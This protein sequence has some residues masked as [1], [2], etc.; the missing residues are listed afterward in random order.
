MDQLQDIWYSIRDN[1]LEIWDGLQEQIPFLS[2]IP[3]YKVYIISGAAV[4]MS[5]L[6]VVKTL[7][8]N[9][10]AA[11]LEASAANY[12][13]GQQQ[14]SSVLGD[15][16]TIG[17]SDDAKEI[18]GI[19]NLTLQYKSLTSLPSNSG[20]KTMQKNLGIGDSQTA[21]ENED[22]NSAMSSTIKEF[23][24]NYGGALVVPGT[25]GTSS[26]KLAAY[27]QTS[28]MK[29]HSDSL[30]S[31]VL[32]EKISRVIENTNYGESDTR[33]TLIFLSA[34]NVQGLS[35]VKTGSALYTLFGDED[36]VGNKE[37]NKYICTGIAEGTY[38]TTGDESEKSGIRAEDEEDDTYAEEEDTSYSDSEDVTTEDSAAEDSTE[39]AE[40]VSTEASVPTLMTDAS[41]L[42][43][44]EDDIVDGETSYN[45]DGT[46][47]EEWA[48]E[49]EDKETVSS[50]VD[51]EDEDENDD[52]DSGSSSKGSSDDGLPTTSKY[53][54]NAA[55]VI[56]E[57][58]NPLTDNKTADLIL[59][60]YSKSTGKVTITYW[61][62]SGS[63]A[64]NKAESQSTQSYVTTEASEDSV[65]EN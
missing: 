3:R 27:N 1:A 14:I 9:Q 50:A 56:D 65:E 47:N 22:Y 2:E 57:K 37:T 15:S 64:A 28:K 54:V 41:Q 31:N 60:K 42:V 38:V 4:L 10:T 34:A 16:T 13:A 52:S 36:T 30:I 26:L 8:T 49:N 46:V 55:L 20:I 59:Y 53:D 35:S 48:S 7:E 62:L 17:L 51:N 5:L 29:S 12:K 6:C 19:T 61:N 23:A 11:Q 24:G 18:I 33:N 63:D 32:Y 21:S 44:T 43:I 45:S 25:V 39:D 40:E 58:G